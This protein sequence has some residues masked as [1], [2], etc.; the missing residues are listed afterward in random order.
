MRTTALEFKG[1]N[2]TAFVKNKR[3]KCYPII[4]D[5][6]IPNNASN[7]ANTYI[8]IGV[9]VHRSGVWKG[10]KI[11]STSTGILLLPKLDLTMV[12]REMFDF[13]AMLSI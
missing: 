10:K 13:L 12:D 9:H 2:H 11:E 6:Y 7:N 1:L 8:L 5:L 3:V 4:G